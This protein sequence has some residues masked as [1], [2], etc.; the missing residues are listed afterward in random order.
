MRPRA[1]VFILNVLNDQKIARQAR[2]YRG[3]CSLLI[4]FF[5]LLFLEVNAPAAKQAHVRISV[6]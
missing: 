2:S 5:I 4:R 6:G 1:V 3:L